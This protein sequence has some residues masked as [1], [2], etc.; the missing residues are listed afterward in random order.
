MPA[1][2][3]VDPAPDSWIWTSPP[4]GTGRSPVLVTTRVVAGGWPSTVSTGVAGPV[5]VAATPSIW[6]STWEVV[7]LPATVTDSWSQ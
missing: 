3:R 4:A 6:I 7:V 1:T 5:T 2:V